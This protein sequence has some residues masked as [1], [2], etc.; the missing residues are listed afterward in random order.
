MPLLIILSVLTVWGVAGVHESCGGKT[1]A[2]SQ[3][4]LDEILKQT[5]GKSQKEAQAIVR[6]Y[7]K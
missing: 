3:G 2:L 7:G 6:G 4:D 1:P 5:C